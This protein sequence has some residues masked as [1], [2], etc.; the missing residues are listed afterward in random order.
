M[1]GLSK[2]LFFVSTLILCAGCATEG[3]SQRMGGMSPEAQK[4]AEEARAN[5]DPNGEKVSLDATM[6]RYRYQSV[7]LTDDE[8][9]KTVIVCKWLIPKGTKFAQKICR[10]KEE[11]AETRSWSQ[12]NVRDIQRGNTNAKCA[13]C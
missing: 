6:D 10:T 13:G 8:T 4:L 1:S 7:Q 2:F 5:S 3:T 12:R 9:G 11:W